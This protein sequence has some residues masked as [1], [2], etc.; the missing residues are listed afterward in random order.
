MKRAPDI[1]LATAAIAC[2]ALMG[3]RVA[4]A[5]H[6]GPYIFTTGS[7]AESLFSL[8]K[9]VNKQTVYANPFE[10]P[11]AQSYFNWLYYIVYGAFTSAVMT[12]TKLA[13]TELPVIARCLTVSLT[14]LCMFFVYRIL[15]PLSLG[16]RLAGSAI[17][18]FNPLIGFWC[19]T[20]RPDIAALACAL[21]G[22]WCMR[23]A[24][25][26]RSSM[27]WIGLAFV[28][29]YCAWAFKQIYVA[30]FVAT[31]LHLFLTRKR[32]QAFWFAGAAI[33][34]IGLTLIAGT[35]EYRYAVIFSQAQMEIF[36]S[37]AVHRLGKAFLKAPLFLFGLTSLIECL[38]RDRT[39][40]LAI[41]AFI[42]LP[43]MFAASAKGGASDNYFFEPAAL[44]SIL[45]LLEGRHVTAAAV[46]QLASPILIAA[47]FRRSAFRSARN[48]LCIAPVAP[49][50]IEWNSNRH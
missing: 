29:F 28:A 9:W 46:A 43:L 39:N 49:R 21:A 18:A 36:P 16:R 2:T 25:R 41:W 24:E 42:S 1:A 22:L 10:P 15:S 38:R 45:F 32:Q 27:V 6:H 8:W 5:L 14:G 35:P 34:A 47:G 30:A 17:I 50:R 48:P 4:N 19:V 11:Y 20:A 7:E 40:L 3:A 23:N 12:M 44:C 31:A 37:D 13:S 26:A 33:L